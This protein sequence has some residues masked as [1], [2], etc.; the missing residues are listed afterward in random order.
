MK[1][2]HDLLERAFDSGVR[3][4]LIIHVQAH[5]VNSE[6]L[7]DEVREFLLEMDS[8]VKALEKGWPTIVKDMGFNPTNVED[9]DEDDE[10]GE[11]FVV[12]CRADRLV[13]VCPVQFL[14]EMLTTSWKCEK[15]DAS[16][17]E[18]CG[19][20]RSSG[21]YMHWHAVDNICDAMLQAVERAEAMRLES[22]NKAVA[23]GRVYPKPIETPE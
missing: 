2:P 3:A 14:V 11:D 16:M 10:Y 22:W 19:S 15:A 7:S 18:G 9:D 6:E 21:W 8:Q 4:G 13:R 5:L 20:W 23:E 12:S 17:T 1:I